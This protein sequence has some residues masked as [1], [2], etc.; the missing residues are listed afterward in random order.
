MVNKELLDMLRCPNC[1]Q[2]KDGFLSR[3]QECWLI[4]QDCSRKYPI[5]ED[6]PVMLIDEG[7]K[8]IEIK[9]EDLPVPP[10]PLK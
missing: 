7:D 5:V 8:W 4:C 6:I 3:Y 9:K 2:E 1:V 10:P